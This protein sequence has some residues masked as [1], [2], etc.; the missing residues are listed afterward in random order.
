MSGICFFESEHKRIDPRLLSDLNM[1]GIFG[2]GVCEVL[3]DACTVE[4]AEMRQEIFTQL[5]CGRLGAAFS[6]LYKTIRSLRYKLRYYS[7][8]HSRLE[9]AVTSYY[10]CELYVGIYDAVISCETES[11][12]LLELIENQKKQKELIEKI[13][14]ELES[15]DIDIILSS[16]AFAQ[17][18]SVTLTEEDGIPLCEKI[19]LLAG[20]IGIP[21]KTKTND[22]HYHIAFEAAD[23]ILRLHKEETDRL[24]KL[25]KYIELFDLSVLALEDEL[26]FYLKIYS[27]TEEAHRLG[28]HTCIP[29]F[30]KERGLKATDAYDI[31]LLR[32][33]TIVPNDIDF[34][35]DNGQV[36]IVGVN[37]GGKTTYLRAVAVNIVLALSGCPVFCRSMEVFPFD[38]IFIHFPKSAEECTESGNYYEE[39]QRLNAIVEG[40]D[41]SS[42]CFLNE[43][44]SATDDIRGTRMAIDTARRLRGKG[45]FLLYV[46]HFVN[47]IDSEFPTLV[48]GA[49]SMTEGK[50]KISAGVAKGVSFTKDILDRYG[51]S[52]SQL[53]ERFGVTWK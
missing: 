49:A 31:T 48:A 2:D 37:G 10:I 1:N 39:L 45:A 35:T 43:T 18:N 5:R 51:L 4:Q 8:A 24:L 14:N 12:L 19:A 46:T 36:F 38:R 53:G 15:I 11:V 34:G 20:N 17:G 22:I 32:S 44:F 25:E 23:G 7:E 52:K 16:Y 47:V 13:R 21:V 40:A 29:R 6:L 30:M 27:V 50:Y 28:I 3:S 9:K 26:D 41:S 42:F 33:N